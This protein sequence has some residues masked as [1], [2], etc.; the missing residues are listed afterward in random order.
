[1]E[2]ASLGTL[3]EDLK[4]SFRFA[5]KNVISI[6]LAMLGV[7]LVTAVI[8]LFMI[9]FVASPL[10]F[11]IGLEAMIDFFVSWVEPFPPVDAA[12]FLGLLLFL[13]LPI[14]APL[15][16]AFGALFGMAREIVESEGTTAE[17]VFVWYQRKFFSLAAGG[18]ILFI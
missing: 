6:F 8:L 18:I 4:V 13:V 15:F 3:I 2:D 11:T 12:A 10:F 14:L 1:M 17:G 5:F 9:I 16:V 7:L